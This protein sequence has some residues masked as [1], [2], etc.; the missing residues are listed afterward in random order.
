[1]LVIG[2]KGLVGSLHYLDKPCYCVDTVFFI[3]KTSTNESIKWLYYCFYI[4]DLSLNPIG[5]GPPGISR[6]SI[7]L[8]HLL[9]PPPLSKQQAIANFLDKKTKQIDSYIEQKQK[10]V[11]L[12]RNPKN[13][14]H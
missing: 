9:I 10:N 13:S 11:R 6:E 7:Y 2:R 1:M 3:D 8:K 14:N 12:V 4:L 5:S